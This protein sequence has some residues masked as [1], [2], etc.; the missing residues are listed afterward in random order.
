MKGNRRSKLKAL[1]G[2]A[3]A[4]L[5]MLGLAACSSNDADEDA[6]VAEAPQ[7]NA[8]KSVANY[9]EADSAFA[10]NDQYGA[11]VSE[12]ASAASEAPEMPEAESQALG[13]SQAAVGGGI[14]ANSDNAAGMDR[15]VIYRANM[16][17]KV[18]KFETAEEQLTNLIHMSPGAYILQF[19]DSRNP[20]EKGA[21]YVVKVP[22]NGFNSFLDGLKKIK[23]IYQER[24][25]QGN[26]VTE[27]YVD[28]GA[29]L[30][31]KQVVEERLLGFMDKAT[32]TDDLVKFSNELAR[33]QEEIEQLKGRMRYLDQNVAFSTVSIRLYQSEHAEAK[34]EEE[35]EDK[36]FGDRIYDALSGSANVLRQFG[37]GLL[38]VIA[39]LLPVLVVLTV[40]GI[41]AYVVMRRRHAAR[42][43]SAEA[44]RREM[45]AHNRSLSD[46]AEGDEDE[47]E[48]ISSKEEETPDTNEVDRKE[49]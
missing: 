36:S 16:V 6:A 48:R 44:R 37:E 19:N 45:I 1:L 28:L 32:R 46:T 26:D 22:S 41:P 13:G 8:A 27:E 29:R 4:V 40:I 10:M 15:K 23:T 38:V 31:A 9:N 14:G 12:G 43:A 7:A 42:R 21:S 18:E 30:K 25:L 5:L 39:A 34:A 3:M 24:D 35:P 49:I 47:S 20:D 2:I 17:M 33:V 11:P